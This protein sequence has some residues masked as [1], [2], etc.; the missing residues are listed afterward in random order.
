MAVIR[1][2]PNELN[3]YAYSLSMHAREIETAIIEMKKINNE[4]IKKWS[5]SEFEQ[6]YNLMEDCENM[7][8]KELISFS[9]E[10]AARVKKIA[11]ELEC[12]EEQIVRNIFGG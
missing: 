1:T 12:A 11:G 10:Y 6:L 5:G 2:T 9:E 4:L 8:L 3:E 7:S